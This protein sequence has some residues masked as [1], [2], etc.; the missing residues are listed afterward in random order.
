MAENWRWSFL[1]LLWASGFAFIVLFITL[2]ETY[3]PTILYRRAQRLRKLTGNQAL[4]AP[5]EVGDK[6]L[7]LLATIG[8]NIK[9]AIRL[10]TE[11]AILVANI[12]IALVCASFLPLFP[13]FPAFD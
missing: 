5:C 4:R 13:S 10:M 9:R 6:R 1:I 3:E 12:Y 2:P 11:P 7:S 8:Q